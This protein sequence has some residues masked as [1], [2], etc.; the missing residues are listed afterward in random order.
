MFK[1]TTSDCD[2]PKIVLIQW[3]QS[4][5]LVSLFGQALS[6]Q[7]GMDNHLQTLLAVPQAMRHLV[8]LRTAKSSSK[9]PWKAK[10]LPA[11][12]LDKHCHPT[13][14]ALNGITDSISFPF[15]ASNGPDKTISSLYHLWIHGA[16]WNSV[17]HFHGTETRIGFQLSGLTELPQTC[18][19]PKAKLH[20]LG[21][22]EL[23]QNSHT[24]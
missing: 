11:S 2:L 4:L 17:L 9:R 3:V 15:P 20:P 8:R 16:E 22:P 14:I 21:K 1:S 10:A 18:S 24:P 12:L 19:T 6:L 23:K 13:L 7:E 5:A